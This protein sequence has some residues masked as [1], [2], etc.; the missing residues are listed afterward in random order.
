MGCIERVPSI[1]W[2]HVE[3]VDVVEVTI[4]GLGH[5]G[6]RPPVAFHIGGSVLDLPGD[7]GIPNNP[8]TVSIG[9]EHGPV[10][11]AGVIHPCGASHLA[12]SIEC[13]P[14]GKNCV[15]GILATWMNGRDS[16][17]YGALADHQLA[18]AG[19]QSRVSHFHTFDVGDCV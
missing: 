5:H 11:E 14:G 18:V 12:V 17:A 1:L 6:Q 9:D 3:P 19:N 8:Y 2:F 16:G 4:P 13:E 15:I 10:E 7:H